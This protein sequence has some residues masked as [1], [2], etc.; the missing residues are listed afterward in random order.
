MS[1]ATI[2]SLVLILA[3]TWSVMCRVNQMQ[4]GV[5]KFVVFA[6][7]AALGLGLVGG[8]VLPPEWGRVS[9]AGGVFLFLLASSKRWHHQAP[10]GTEV[11]DEHEQKGPS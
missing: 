2:I 10:P 1:P 5:T 7:H 4:H 11:A 3:A 9:L 8:L 6:Q